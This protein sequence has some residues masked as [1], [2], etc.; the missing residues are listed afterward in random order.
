MITLRKDH[1][2]KPVRRHRDQDNASSSWIEHGILGTQLGPNKNGERRDGLLYQCAVG[3]ARRQ[4]YVAEG[5]IRRHLVEVDVHVPSWPLVRSGRRKR[6]AA[7][8]TAA[9]T[10]PMSI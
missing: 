6:T 4:V 7:P 10:G 3:P 8:G 1:Y 9:C 2:E 5:R